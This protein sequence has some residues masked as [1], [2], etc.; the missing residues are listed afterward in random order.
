M[1]NLVTTAG[2]LLGAR[3]PS[4]LA[5]YLGSNLAYYLLVDAAGYLGAFTALG[6]LALM[7]VAILARLIGFVGMLLVLRDRLPHL[8]ERAPLPESRAERRDAFGDALFAGILPFFAFYTAWK[9]LQADM[10][11]YLQK[12]LSVQS[13][14]WFESILTGVEP[15]TEGTLDNLVFEPITVVMIGV[16]FAG[17]LLWK[18]HQSRLPRVLALVAFYLETMWVFLTVTLLSGLA[19]SVTEWVSTRQ[20]MVWL[21]GLRGWLGEHLAL[22][23]WIWDGV[24]WLLGQVGGVALAPIAWLTIA[25][26][27]FGQAVAPQAPEFGHAAIVVARQRYESL[28]ERVRARL[29][30]VSE[31]VLDVFRPIGKVMVLMW[32][33]GPVLIGGY[34]LLYTLA[35]V[36]AQGWLQLALT[37]GIGPQELQP[38]W[39]LLWSGIVVAV[40]MIFEPLRIAIVAAAYDQTI[41]RMP[42][43]VEVPS[44]G[45]GVDPEAQELREGAGHDHLEVERADGVE[46][47]EEAGAGGVAVGSLRVTTDGDLGGPL[48]LPRA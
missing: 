7:P 10:A 23:A 25:G 45:S 22:L 47:D 31:Q 18:K 34:I 37:R 12:A 40:G 46:R 32:R 35:V 39:W 41:S 44:H 20:A 27:I 13:A 3:W 9:F 42:P 1:R 11:D 17:R 30:D 28:P 5:W 15:V 14:L 19:D 21:A 6:G 24:E 16:C 48:D 8:S 26:V 2:R 43:P 29:A 33:A 38:T 36:A 4:L